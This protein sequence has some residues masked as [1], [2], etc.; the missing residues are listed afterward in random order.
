MLSNFK[1][2]PKYTLILILF[3]YLICFLCLPPLVFSKCPGCLEAPSRGKIVLRYFYN[4]NDPTNIQ[5]TNLLSNIVSSYS[6]FDLEMRDMSKSEDREFR[7]LLNEVYNIKDTDKMTAPA[8][9]VGESVF[10][11]S[12]DIQSG[13]KALIFDIS[14]E[15]KK[16]SQRVIY[17]L[18]YV[19]ILAIF[20]LNKLLWAFIVVAGLIDGINPC[21]LSVLIF[22]ISF[23]SLEKKKKAIF[24]VG[25]SFNIGVF[26]AY[27]T[28]GL[29]LLKF[30][31]S[32]LSTKALDWFY[33]L[34]G[35]ISF[36]LGI[37]SIVDFYKAKAG[38]FKEMKLQLP[39]YI[40][41]VEHKL[42][43]ENVR[44][45]RNNAII[46]FSLGIL[47]S[48]FE[49]VCTGQIYFPTI[50]IM[51]SNWSGIIRI[52]YLLLYNLM[53]IT[54]SILIL[55]SSILIINL[56]EYILS[57]KSIANVKILTACVFFILGAYMFGI[58]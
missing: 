13:L 50:T 37:I 17:F 39:K 52:L 36:L 46:G 9:F 26:I 58:L 22:L 3:L 11:G 53:F 33:P 28:I 8:L 34:L 21:A 7:N 6:Y 40:K 24:T 14:S 43:R 54:P 29:G 25:I 45:L 48:A 12:S 42:I 16:L 30:T 44:S 31:H 10:I 55:I 23:L 4:K 51:N 32:F 1:L 57:P 35:G 20:N 2:K 27:F 18:R 56:Q 47:I 38:R 49:L 19:R 41:M 5:I 15:P